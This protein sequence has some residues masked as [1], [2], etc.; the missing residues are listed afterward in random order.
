MRARRRARVLSISPR[1]QRR[2]S[3]ETCSLRLRPVWILSATA[4]G[5]FLEETDDVGVD[6]LVGGCGGAGLVVFADGGQRVTDEGRFFGGEDAYA[7]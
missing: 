5:L 4:A 3:R 1:S 6:V 7:G 2:T